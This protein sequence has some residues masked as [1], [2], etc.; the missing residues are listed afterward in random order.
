MDLVLA[1]ALLGVLAL[2]FSRALPDLADGWMTIAAAFVG[3]LPVLW[4]AVDSL[5][6][7]EW[8]SM[9]LLA[10][11]ALVFSL[12]SQEWAP[13]VFIELMLSAARILDGFTRD[14]TEKS[15]RGLL[16]LRPETAQVEREG[17]LER[18]P[19]GDI[20]V[21]DIVVSDIGER[22]P[23]DGI[24]LSGSAA[25]DE[26]SLTGESLPVDKG[27]GS[28]VMSSSLIH[29]GSI[30]VR[31]THVGQDTAL[32]R[33]IRLVESA[34]E[35]KPKAQ[36]LGEKFGKIYL[37]SV[38][39]GS[40]LLYAT[41]GNLPLVLAMVLVVCADDVAIAIP[42]AYLRA[43]NSA[44][45]MGVIIKGSK[46]LETF[47]QV[48]TIVFDKTGTL[49]V[50]L[51]EI[52]GIFA[53]SGY[54]EK[55]VLEAAS[56]SGAR[57]LHPLSRAVLSYTNK[58]G[59]KERLPDSAEEKGGRGVITKIGKDS[60][61]MGKKV[62]LEELGMKFPADMAEKAEEESG[63][64]RSVSFIAKNGKVIGL[65]AASDK[66]KDNVAKAIADLRSLGV[67][68]IV[69]L[70]G[71]NNRVAE[72]MSK[73]L[74]IDEW[75][76]EL[77]PEDKVKI[78]RQLET[79]G[80]VA[81]VGDGVNDAAALSIANVGI[82]MGGLGA[83]GTID[84]AQIVLMRDDLSTLPETM[85]IARSARRISVQDFWIW[86]ASNAAGMVLVLCGVI[87]PAGAAAYNFLSD[88]LPLSNSI[89]V[90]T[91]KKRGI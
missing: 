15:I 35:E 14:R 6:K 80:S 17:K 37:I 32:E 20:T 91:K 58:K 38:F 12:V 60:I 42:I 78:I 26:S 31:A 75:Y 70:T 27:E 44:A 33:I 7:R 74:G 73:E 57:S 9:D 13:A 53:S 11:V 34:R 47:G 55:E 24:V 81:M 43:I 18:I 2:H 23:V 62:F 86:G 76:A 56:I 51:L 4:R 63:K 22:V 72:T 8:A 28:R 59:I 50:G 68:K 48:K 52:T 21:G 87:G 61:A 49:T 25:V 79:T 29:S 36:T 89:R 88:F 10:S 41:T 90:G 19:V 30:C 16:K 39:A 69:M 85:R 1:A 64:G 66:V 40:A 65:A 83:E 77:M 67:R 54:S 71:D 82:A 3:L 45:S 84:S 5:R 46:H